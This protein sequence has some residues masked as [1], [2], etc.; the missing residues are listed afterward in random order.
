MCL[1]DKL[2]DRRTLKNFGVTSCFQVSHFYNYKDSKV[3]TWKF[4]STKV[5]ESS[6][7]I[8]LRFMKLVLEDNKTA[9]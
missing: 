4:S 2:S 7:I 3:L 8:L 6:Q 1:M 9:P 5:E